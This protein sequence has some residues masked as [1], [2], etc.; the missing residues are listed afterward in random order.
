MRRPTAPL[1]LSTSPH[2]ASEVLHGVWI[3]ER[4]LRGNEEHCSEEDV[5]QRLCLHTS[6]SKRSFPTLNHS[7]QPPPIFLHA[8]IVELASRR[9]HLVRDAVPDEHYYLVN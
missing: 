7:E 4:E 1:A 5:E 6:L 3:V 9:L 8:N 2:N